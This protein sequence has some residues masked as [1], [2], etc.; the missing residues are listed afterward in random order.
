LVYKTRDDRESH[1]AYAGPE[2]FEA[3]AHRQIRSTWARRAT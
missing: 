3:R 1:R 2:P